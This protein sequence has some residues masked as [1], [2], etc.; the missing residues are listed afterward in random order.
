VHGQLDQRAAPWLRP[1]GA[2]ARGR[3]GGRGTSC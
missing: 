3:G 2:L 1:R